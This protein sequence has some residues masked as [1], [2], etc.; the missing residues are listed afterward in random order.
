MRA[1]SAGTRYHAHLKLDNNLIPGSSQIYNNHIPVDPDLQGVIQISKTTPLLNVVRGQLV[2][3][4]ITYKNVTDVPLFDVSIADRIPA[5][6]YA[7]VEVIVEAAVALA[8]CR[9]EQTGHMVHDQDL[10]DALGR[11]V[12]TLDGTR[13]LDR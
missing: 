3:Y 11:T 9:P 13:A 7:P 1:R 4:V 10:L 12:M 8:T 2:P 5:D 6:R